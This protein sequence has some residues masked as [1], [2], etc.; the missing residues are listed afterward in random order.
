MIASKGR[1]LT[2]IGILITEVGKAG[3]V[4]P[5]ISVF[6]VFLLVLQP[7]LIKT[8]NK[9]SIGK[10]FMPGDWYFNAQISG[11]SVKETRPIN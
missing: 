7:L 2:L 11:F 1:I 4:R 10:Y 5:G 8:T 6:A 9:R 3:N